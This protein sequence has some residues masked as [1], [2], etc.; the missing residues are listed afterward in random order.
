MQKPSAAILVSEGKSEPDFIA[1]KSPYSLLSTYIFEHINELKQKENIMYGYQLGT[2][3]ANLANI[4]PVKKVHAK[5]LS[6]PGK[7]ILDELGIP[8]E[9]EEMIDFV[10]SSKNL[11]MV[12]PLE[13]SLLNLDNSE[14]IANLK[15][16]YAKE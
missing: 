11:S 6:E 5:F 12:C 14:A 1:Y 7:A 9:F 16:K 15:E 13:T 10:K 3:A 2:V 4:I 8:Y